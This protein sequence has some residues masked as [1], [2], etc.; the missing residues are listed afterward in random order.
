MFGVRSDLFGA[1]AFSRSMNQHEGT[2]E[3]F[4]LTK[5]LGNCFGQSKGQ[6]LYRGISVERGEDV[7]G[8]TRKAGALAG[9]ADKLDAHF[10]RISIALEARMVWRRFGRGKITLEALA[11][12]SRRL[13]EVSFVVLLAAFRDL[14]STVMTHIMT[15]QE[16]V[17]PW[18]AQAADQRCLHAIDALLL[19]LGK[20]ED[21]ICVCVLLAQWAPAADRGR[22]LEI[23]SCSW[24]LRERNDWVSGGFLLESLCVFV[25][26]TLPGL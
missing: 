4:A 2:K 20:A 14:C 15:T 18:V 13:R 26:V 11:V 16:S 19:G 22:S 1:K 9:V 5:D 17:E 21:L 8:G 7:Q 24:F 25:F 10:K 3:I 12:I 23:V 6:I